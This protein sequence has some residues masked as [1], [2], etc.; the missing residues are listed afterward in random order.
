MRCGVRPAANG[1][2]QNKR[3][4]ENTK[5]SLFLRVTRKFR[6]M[7]LEDHPGEIARAIELL[8]EASAK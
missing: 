8:L 2:A 4:V 3:V 1:L 5:C 6:G 7:N